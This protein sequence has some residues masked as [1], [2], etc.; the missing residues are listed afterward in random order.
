[1]AQA[2]TLARDGR[3]KFGDASADGF[4]P[5]DGVGVVV[6]KP[7]ADAVADGDRIRTVIQRSLARHGE[8]ASRRKG[9]IL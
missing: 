6:L 3:S 4:A 7:L 1:M 9:V 5:S 8:P 2:G